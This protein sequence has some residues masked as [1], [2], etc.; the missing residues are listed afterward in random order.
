LR[1][2]SGQEREPLPVFPF[3]CA[4]EREEA[5]DGEGEGAE[6]A[7]RGAKG[8]GGS[9]GCLAALRE[10]AAEV[11]SDVTPFVVRGCA[12]SSARPAWQKHARERTRGGR[13]RD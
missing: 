4:G 5:G 10:F 12:A 7:E 8:G 3:T 9:Q 13:A 1:R 2:K 11:N 6:R